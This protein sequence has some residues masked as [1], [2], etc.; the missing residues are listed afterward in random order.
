[1]VA[2]AKHVHIHGSKLQTKEELEKL[3]AKGAIKQVQGTDMKG[4]YFTVFLVPKKDGQ[5]RAIIN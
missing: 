5:V 4:F 1:M 2:R 3:F